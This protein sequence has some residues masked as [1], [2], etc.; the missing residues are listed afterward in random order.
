[1]ENEPGAS[2]QWKVKSGLGAIDA[3]RL[4]L[5]CTASIASRSDGSIHQSIGF[6]HLRCI[7]AE[8]PRRGRGGA[9]RGAG[10]LPSAGGHPARVSARAVWQMLREAVAS[11]V[12]SAARGC[13]TGRMRARGRTGEGRGGAAT[14]VSGG[15]AEARAQP[16]APATAPAHLHVADR[17]FVPS[18][19]IAAQ[20]PAGQRTR[21]ARRF[22]TRAG[23]PRTAAT[24]GPSCPTIAA[25]AVP[26]HPS[27]SSTTPPVG[28]GSIR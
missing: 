26:A 8:V 12:Q 19:Q 11:P 6:M 15:A 13:G 18:R 7:R 4:N 21:P 23:R 3:L 1:M 5:P 14:G 27:C 10:G 22:S 24:S 17:I 28:D 9:A 20:S 16:R 2:S 25:M